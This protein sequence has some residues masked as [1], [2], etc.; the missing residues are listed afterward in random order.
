MKTL[1]TFFVLLFS[2]S[3]VAGCISGNCVNGYGIYEW[4]NGN[5]I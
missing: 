1:L 2:S 3:V 4:D 5:K